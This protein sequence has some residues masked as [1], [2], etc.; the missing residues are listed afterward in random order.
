MRRYPRFLIAIILG[1]ALHGM[2]VVLYIRQ[3]AWLGYVGGSWGLLAVTI[4]GVVIV[5]SALLNLIKIRKEKIPFAA[6]AQ[7]ISHQAPGVQSHLRPSA[8]TGTA[9]PPT[10]T[11]RAT[12]LEKLTQQVLSDELTRVTALHGKAG[13][14]KTTLAQKLAEDL[15][16]TQAFPGGILWW[17]LGTQ[18][19]ISAA[20]S[21]WAAYAAPSSDITQ[22]SLDVRAEF[23]SARL[24]QKGRL[25][26]ILDDVCQA[27]AAQTLI[28]ILPP[29][30]TIFLTTRDA[31]LAESPYY[32]RHDLAG[33]S[34]DESI[35]LLKKLLPV[36]EKYADAAR[37]VARLTEGIPLAL[38][39]AAGQIRSAAELPALADTLRQNQL[40]DGSVET[41]LAANYATLPSPLQRHFRALG[42]FPAPFDVPALFAVWKEND[43]DSLNIF[44]QQKLLHKDEKNGFLS[45]HAIQ[46]AYADA[47]LRQAPDRTEEQKAS[48]R[49]ADYYLDQLAKTKEL[50]ALG[51]EYV[52]DS[53][54]QFALL[55]PHLQV[56]Y[57]R[58]QKNPT[59]ADL[60]WLST[61]ADKIMY[62]LNQHLTPDRIIPI[63]EIG[64]AAALR[65]NDK[66]SESVHLVNLGIALSNIGETEKAIEFYE[67]ALPLKRETG[68]RAGE[69]RT[70]GNLGLAYTDLGEIHKAI[71]YHQQYLVLTREVKDQRIEAATLR[72]LGLAYASLGNWL[73][74]I[75]HFKQALR[76]DVKIGDRRNEGRS[77]A[78]LGLAYAQWGD[79]RIAIEYYEQALKVTREIGD[80]RGEGSVLGNLG[81]VYYD[82][83]DAYSAVEYYEKHLNTTREIGDRR[84]EGN[85]L[86]NLG[87]AYKKL[88]DPFT[89]MEY[90]EQALVIDRAIDDKLGEAN[91]CW[92]IGILLEE[93]GKFERAVEMLQVRVDYLTSIGHADVDK[94][95]R[96]LDDVRERWK[97]AGETT[98][99]KINL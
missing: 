96:Y 83:G 77:L 40:P 12:E 97:T 21:A 95:V 54:Y 59:G 47:L 58:S 76:I 38:E 45:Q 14:G 66:Q 37:E 33:L 85:A 19:D 15:A 91:D 1:I 44:M 24:A 31:D 72:N 3:P 29:G 55:W 8:S 71:D 80:R 39:L 10:F 90:Y 13:I 16:H 64:L 84:G 92:N 7:G 60:R 62:T 75:E 88:G 67:Q 41:C 46:C 86:G 70:L 9:L 26:V 42:I 74:S 81:I 6:N 53:L 89:A 27:E 22:L 18:P 28:D 68:D 49:H 61:F 25:C 63:L 94:Y 98:P 35:E 5:I 52:L 79:S 34:E 36:P 30:T 11:G 43:S 57:E 99:D 78:N 65:L 48:H 23:V 56:A 87:I 51:G 69:G 20:L 93:Q 50:N 4:L 82:L 2:V 73:Q 32:H 17:T